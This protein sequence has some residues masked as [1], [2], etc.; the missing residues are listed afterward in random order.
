MRPVEIIPGMGEEGDK[1]EKD[2]VNATTVYCKNF[3][4]VTM[5]PQ[6]NNK[7]PSSTVK[8]SNIRTSAWTIILNYILKPL[9]ERF[10]DAF[11]C[12]VRSD[13]LAPREL[14]VRY[15]MCRNRRCNI[16]TTNPTNILCML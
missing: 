5:C 2:G 8:K 4:N 7:K 13:L 6:Y 1:G 12:R 15:Y 11:Y 9:S 10:M 14:A 16:E 3:V